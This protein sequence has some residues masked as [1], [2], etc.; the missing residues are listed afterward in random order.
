MSLAGTPAAQASPGLQPGVKRFKLTVLGTTDLH[1]NVLNWDY[2]KDVPYTD[3]AGNRIGI[4]QASTLIKAMRAERGAGNCLTLDA[5]DTIQE[6]RWPTT[7]PRLNLLPGQS[8][9]LWRLP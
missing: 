5:G 7:M 4:A 3:S 6:R 9:I 1:N 2:F 8:S